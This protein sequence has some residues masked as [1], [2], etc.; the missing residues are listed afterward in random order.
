M[1]D[2]LIIIAFEREMCV[3]VVGSLGL[4]SCTGYTMYFIALIPLELFGLE[5]NAIIIIV[6]RFVVG[7]FFF[8]LAL[9]VFVFLYIYIFVL[10]HFVKSFFYYHFY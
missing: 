10:E 3:C 9:C 2:D 5:H 6:R 4:A 8:L 1:L 7:T